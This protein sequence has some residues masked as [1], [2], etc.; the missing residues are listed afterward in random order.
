MPACCLRLR[1]KRSSLRP[2]SCN[3]FPLSSSPTFLLLILTFIFL[4]KPG[5][6][7]SAIAKAGRKPPANQGNVSLLEAEA[8][9]KQNISSGQFTFT[10]DAEASG[11]VSWPLK[12]M[13]PSYSSPEP[14][15]GR[16]IP[17]QAKTQT[18]SS[19]QTDPPPPPRRGSRGSTDT[20]Q[21]PFNKNGNPPA[22][23]RRKKRPTGQEYLIAARERR[24]QQQL[25]NLH[26]PQAPE[27]QWI[28]EFCEYER[29]FG[30]P[31]LALIRQYEMKDHRHRKQEAE[32]K[33]LLEKA[34]MK[35]RKS[36]KSARPPGA[37]NAAVADDHHTASRH[38]S[39]AQTHSSTPRE[40]GEA[41]YDDAEPGDDDDP[42]DE[43]PYHETM[44]LPPGAYPQDPTNNIKR[45]G[46][47]QGGSGGSGRLKS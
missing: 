15:E 41:Y 5:I 2:C 29:I 22:T 40:A 45:P 13:G 17:A 1:S 38:G 24:E 9:R 4:A 6:I 26:N 37:K 19:T 44:P 47:G 3:Y 34:K 28:C 25:K 42:G 7:S 10:Y 30:T 23:T 46:G 20:A 35:G 33:R 21:P 31:P 43:H 12:T 39:V 32:H 8:T 11:G 36:K 27:D 14:K 18:Q 16:N